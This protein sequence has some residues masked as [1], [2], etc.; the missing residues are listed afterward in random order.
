LQKEDND[1][2]KKCMEYEVEGSRPRGRVVDQRG[3]GCVVERRLWKKDHQAH[4]LTRRMLWIVAD[5]GS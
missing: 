3:P 2:V 4:K 5:G 1:Y